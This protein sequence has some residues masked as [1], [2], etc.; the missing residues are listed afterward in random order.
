MRTFTQWLSEAKVG[1][2]TFS[3]KDPVTMQVVADWLEENGDRITQVRGREVSLMQYL[4]WRSATILEIERAILQ[5]TQAPLPTTGRI[6]S[7]R[8]NVP[9]SFCQEGLAAL[10]GPSQI[11]MS[12][13]GMGVMSKREYLLDPANRRRKAIS[14]TDDLQGRYGPQEQT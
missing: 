6:K 5:V 4:R 10:A 2:L 11:S 9:L 13:C 14:V 12:V 1:P 3:M 8:V 7:A